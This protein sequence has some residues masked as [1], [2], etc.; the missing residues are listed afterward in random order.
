M[1][2]AHWPKTLQ[3]IVNWLEPNYQK[4][5]MEAMR[6]SDAKAIVYAS[7][8]G[9]Y[10]DLHEVEATEGHPVGKPISTYGASKLA[11]EALISAYCNMFGLR[12]RA[13]R[14]GNVIGPRQTHGVGYEFVRR[15][16]KTPDVLDILG[17]GKQSKSYI[18]VDD[19]VD[20][21]FAAHVAEGDPFD[22]FNVATG[23]Y[24]TVA[25]I[26][27]L[28]VA[29]LGLPAG[30]VRYRYSG[31]DRGWKGDV[32]IVRLGTARIRALG[33]QCKRSTRDAMR[34]ALASMVDEIRA[35]RP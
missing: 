32:P 34:L 26:A 10:G 11:G 2:P 24:V 14:F 30:S 31:G 20:A 1:E 12:G 22:V 18:H 5:V 3:P 19:V 7:G 15:L 25:E 13:F 35:G 9:V 16:L 23:D 6:L 27:D 29:S 33:W 4:G 28:A 8:S 21:V 17:D